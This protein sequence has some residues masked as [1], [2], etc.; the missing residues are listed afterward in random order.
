[1][2]SALQR[3]IRILLVD[4][5]P[6]VRAGVRAVLQGQSDFEL[7]GEAEDGLD[8]VQQVAAQRPDV[9]VLDLVLRGIQG[10]EV[11]RQIQD[12][13]S[14]AGVVV[15]TMHDDLAYVVEA[16]RTGAA[17][18]VLKSGPPDEIVRAIRAAVQGQRYLSP[19]LVQSEIDAVARRWA[20][21]RLDLYAIL[22]P[23]E[24]Q[25]CQLAAQGYTND[26]IAVELRIRRRTV[27]SHRFRMMHKLGLRN[28]AE[29]VAFA[30]RRGIIP[31]P[32][33]GRD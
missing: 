23:R 19:P 5:H 21:G 26:A 16:L 29:L 20:D 8:A 17:G 25:V 11:L 28:Q 22:T 24:R 32:D 27:E 13:P 9:V 1:M 10:L 2:A 14:R 33:E 12:G 30:F 15:L 7:V 6:V 3:P 31:K 4:D 18:Y